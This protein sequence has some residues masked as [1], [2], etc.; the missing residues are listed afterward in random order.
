[1]TKAATRAVELN[2]VEGFDVKVLRDG[3]PVDTSQHGLPGYP[4]DRA[5]DGDVTVEEWRKTRFCKTYPGYDCV[6][7]YGDGTPAHGDTKL[8]NVRETY[9][10]E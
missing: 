1:M 3:N 9:G 10:G 5:A 2:Q 4:Y 8:E 7:L 6:V